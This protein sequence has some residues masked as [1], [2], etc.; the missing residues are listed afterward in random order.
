MK[1]IDYFLKILPK[2]VDKIKKNIREINLCISKQIM[3]HFT[4]P[5]FFGKMKDPDIVGKAGNPAAGIC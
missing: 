1:E 4:K 5:K 3:Q 2:V